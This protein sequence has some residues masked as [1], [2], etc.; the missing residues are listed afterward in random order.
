MAA[1]FAGQ[2]VSQL[3]VVGQVAVMCEANTVLRVHIERLRFG[4]PGTASCRVTN[5]TDSHMP[6]QP[7]HVP[8]PK[9][10]TY[11]P[12][13]LALLEPELLAPGHDARCVLA[14]VL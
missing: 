1:V 10:V 3:I 4:R 5:M 2:E 14:A 6:L 13:A 11:Q 12:V 7:Q 8:L 9:H